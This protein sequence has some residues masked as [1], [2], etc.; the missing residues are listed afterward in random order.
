MFSMLFNSFDLCAFIETPFPNEVKAV[1]FDC[2]GALVDT[3][4][5]SVSELPIEP[6]KSFEIMSFKVDEDLEKDPTTSAKECLQDFLQKGG[7]LQ[8]ISDLSSITQPNVDLHVGDAVYPVCSGGWCRSQA[9][10]AILKPYSD[11]I[12]LFPPHAARVGWDPYN[13]KINRYR[14]YAQEIVPDE[15]SLY[16]G[17]DKA[18]RFGFEHDSSWKLVEGSPTAEGMKEISQF[19]DQN[20]FGPNSSWQGKQG[21]RRIYIAFSNNAHVV[22][23]RLNQSNKSLR[24]VTVVAINS[25]DMITY[26]PDFLNTTPRSTKSYQH[27]SKLLTGLFD[28]LEFA[29]IK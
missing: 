11:Q 4:Y 3:E 20:Y 18:L 14:N 25:E 1:M 6:S 26:P 17:I 8:S 15:F 22:I 19:Y 24:G 29:N 21:K 9:L 23:Q 12:I 2:D 7:V 16:F 10:W 5:L 28:F 27:F 13:G